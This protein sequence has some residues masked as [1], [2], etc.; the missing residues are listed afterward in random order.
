MPW[1]TKHT[2]LQERNN[3]NIEDTVAL[4]DAGASVPGLPAVRGNLLTGPQQVVR[5]ALALITK[6]GGINLP[7]GARV[8]EARLEIT[9]AYTTGATI[10]IGTASTPTA[11]QTTAQN[12]PQRANVPN[13]FVIHQDTAAD[14]EP[15]RITIAGS[16]SVGA[17]FVTLRYTVPHE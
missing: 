15:P 4:I 7:V 3:V 12:N 11:F 2:S 16:P 17:G 14:N 10:S 13:T 8:Q 9:T 5:I 1:H 6:D